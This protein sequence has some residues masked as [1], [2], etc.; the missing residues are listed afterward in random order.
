[1]FLKQG[2][3]VNT[4]PR[5][6]Q[7]D[8]TL[9]GPD[10]GGIALTYIQEYQLE[11]RWLL[12]STCSTGHCCEYNQRASEQSYPQGFQAATATHQSV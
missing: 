7:G 6:N 3:D 5:V 2:Q 10:Y 4:T 12:V 8:F 9:W 11:G 1:M